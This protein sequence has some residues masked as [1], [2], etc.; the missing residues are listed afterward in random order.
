MSR[1]PPPLH[2]PTPM[3]V[4]DLNVWPGPVRSALWVVAALVFVLLSSLFN[5]VQASNI[6]WSIGINVPAPGYV[7]QHRQPEV[8]YVVPG[9][10]QVVY[11]PAAYPPVVY[12]QPGYVQPGHPVVVYR[13]P[14]HV[15]PVPPVAYQ[16]PPHPHAGHHHGRPHWEGRPHGHR[17]H[18]G[19]ERWN[20]GGRWERH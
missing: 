5:P 18:R 2:L 8:V 14:F 3:P 1:L 15:H 4:H 19:E 7:T 12:Q 16:R 11:P 6:S 17:G 10:P 20:N 13:S 9:Y